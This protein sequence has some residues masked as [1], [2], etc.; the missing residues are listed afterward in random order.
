MS[1][2][3]LKGNLAKSFQLGLLIALVLLLAFAG[4]AKA[5]PVASVA[6]GRTECRSM[7]SKILARTV[8]YCVFFPPDY[9]ANKDQKFPVL[10]FLHGL[11]ENAQ[12]LLNAGGWN[13]IE[14]LWEEKRIGDFLMV[15]PAAGRSFYINSRDGKIRYE[16]FF[17]RE[18]LPFI[19]THYRIRAVRADRGIT[20]ISM[21]GYGA[22]RLS[23]KYPQ[24]FGSVSAHSAALVAKLPDVQ[25]IGS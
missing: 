12:T 4:E 8:P 17:I 24:L 25:A 7:A 10:Y 23:F 16:D 11:G 2:R 20:G 21:G 6:T 3:L 22:L 9:D 14:N 19:E 18:F 13:L 15:A 1:R 5:G